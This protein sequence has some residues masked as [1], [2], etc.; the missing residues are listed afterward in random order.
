MS[1]YLFGAATSAVIIK[2]TDIIDTNIPNSLMYYVTLYMP[3]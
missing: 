1:N 2:M 3:F